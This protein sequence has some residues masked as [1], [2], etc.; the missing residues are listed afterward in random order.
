[1]RRIWRTKKITEKVKKENEKIEEK[2]EKEI[3]L[4]YEINQ[5]EN[6]IK[7]FGNQFVKNNN[8]KC[9]LIYNGNEL[10]LV[11]NF[12]IA[13]LHNLKKLELKLKIIS[14]LTNL[15]YMFCDCTN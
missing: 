7:I 8:K 9:K 6:D 15:S 12:N 10:E 1:M 2:N 5:D 3:I 11:R 14:N 4:N 13:N